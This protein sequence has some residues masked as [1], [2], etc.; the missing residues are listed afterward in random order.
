MRPALGP[1]L[2]GVMKGTQCA[3]ESGRITAH[4]VERD[5]AVVAVE[6]SVL[7]SLGRDRSAVLLQPRRTSQQCLAREPAAWLLNEAP[8][9]HLL[10][11]AERAGIDF[12]LVTA[13]LRERPL[14]IALAGRVQHRRTVDVGAVHRKTGDELLDRTP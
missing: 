9:Q 3:T 1:E 6:G 8:A 10:E 4:F 11:E 14:K 5:K 2:V 12:S 13:R 7:E